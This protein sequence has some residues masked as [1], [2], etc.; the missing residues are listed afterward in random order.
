MG[1]MS[2]PR[3]VVPLARATPQKMFMI[4]CQTL[5]TLLCCT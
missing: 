5:D 3:I 1:I 2:A 4:K